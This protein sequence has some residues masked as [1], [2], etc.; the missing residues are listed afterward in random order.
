MKYMAPIVGSPNALQSPTTLRPS[1]ESIHPVARDRAR[2]SYPHILQRG[3][4]YANERN[5]NMLDVSLSKTTP[6]SETYQY[7]ASNKTCPHINYP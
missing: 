2:M 6:V 7:K 1:P 5:E 3:L 4:E